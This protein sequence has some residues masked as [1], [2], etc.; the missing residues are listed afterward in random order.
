M[1]LRNKNNK[2]LL[3]LNIK[4][5]KIYITKRELVYVHCTYKGIFKIHVDKIFI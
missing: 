4:E 3:K 2:K 5:T 1:Y